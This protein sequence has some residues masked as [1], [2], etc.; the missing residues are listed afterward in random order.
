VTAELRHHCRQPRC[1]KLPAAGEFTALSLV[2]GPGSLS[3]RDQILVIPQAG[4][5]LEELFRLFRHPLACG[6][7]R[8]EQKAEQVILAGTSNSK[9]E[10][11]LAPLPAAIV[12][13]NRGAK[14]LYT[15]TDGSQPL[16]NP[17]HVLKVDGVVVGFNTFTRPVLCPAVHLP[18]CDQGMSGG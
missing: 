7:L 13:I 12:R 9:D 11:P 3:R 4:P 15:L 1:T 8:L 18:A 17:G 16:G 6:N 2:R 14:A 5:C 10:D